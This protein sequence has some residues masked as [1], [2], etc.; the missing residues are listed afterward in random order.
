MLAVPLTTDT[1]EDQTAV[2]KVTQDNLATPPIYGSSHSTPYNVREFVTIN[3][4]ESLNEHFRHLNST[5]LNRT[6]RT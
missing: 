3:G 5:Q 1:Y 2:T 6:L 4:G